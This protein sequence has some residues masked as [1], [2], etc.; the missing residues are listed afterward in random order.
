MSATPERSSQY[1]A[2][3]V[4]FRPEMYLQM[5][6]IAQPFATARLAAPYQGRKQTNKTTLANTR[7][8]FLG[9]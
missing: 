4:G 9:V 5:A 3:T 1:H 8:K 2:K 6:S 7:Q